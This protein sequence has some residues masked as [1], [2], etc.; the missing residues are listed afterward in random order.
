[1]PHGRRGSQRQPQRTQPFRARCSEEPAHPHVSTA[2]SG[3]S[4]RAAFFLTLPR[5]E[6]PTTVGQTPQRKRTWPNSRDLFH[7]WIC[8][9][10]LHPG[11]GGNNHKPAR[12]PI[13]RCVR[14]PLFSF[15]SLLSADLAWPWPQMCHGSS[16]SATRSPRA[17]CTS[18]D[19]A[20]IR[21]PLSPLRTMPCTRTE[22]ISPSPLPAPFLIFLPP[23]LLQIPTSRPPCRP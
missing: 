14:E 12:C 6:F 23:Q 4:H 22:P 3:P 21:Q 2:P 17:P 1:M 16:R 8:A 5:Q 19:Q 10:I 11:D 15:L 7:Q 9:P 20:L 13:T 18:S